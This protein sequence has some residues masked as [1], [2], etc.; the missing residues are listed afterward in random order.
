MKVT[1]LLA[2]YATVADGKLTVVGGGWSIYG[3]EPI[4]FAIAIK[5]EVP[6]DQTNTEHKLRLELVD[7]DGQPVVVPTPDGEQQLMMEGTFNV[8]RPPTVKPG[9]PI[10][11]PLTQVFPPQPI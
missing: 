8:G 1:M 7:A 11:M 3:P 4:P 10:D 5:L 2:D 6:W 9:T